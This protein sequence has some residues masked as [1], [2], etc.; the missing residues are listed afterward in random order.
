VTRRVLDVGSARGVHSFSLA[1]ESAF[2]V[3]LDLSHSELER[4][5]GEADRRSDVVPVQADATSLPFPARCFDGA[6]LYEVLEHVEDP[7]RVLAEC[8][9]VL[10]PGGAFTMSVPT[11][12]SERLY[13]RL[14]PS[15][16]RQSTHLRIFERDEVL[17]LLNEAGFEVRGQETIHFAPML[18]WFVHCLL[19]TPADHTGAVARNHFVDVAVG[20]AVA[21]ARRAPLLGRGV[22]A[23][24]TRFGKSWRFS[25]VKAPAL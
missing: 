5:A 20:R 25:C 9:R 19:R 4:L 14:H 6:V 11:S 13:W 23:L 16:E 24:A 22:R 10:S 1:E 12:Y 8:C 15:Y 18:A 2:V 3:A 7:A 17:Q 21:V